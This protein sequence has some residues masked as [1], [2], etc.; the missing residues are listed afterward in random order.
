MDERGIKTNS[1]TD[2]L[3]TEKVFILFVF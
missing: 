3:Q 2:C 1:K